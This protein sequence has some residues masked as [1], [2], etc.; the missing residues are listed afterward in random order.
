VKIFKLKGLSK[1][2][3]LRA[4]MYRRSARLQGSIGLLDYSEQALR[5]LHLWESTGVGGVDKG[6][7]GYAYGKWLVDITVKAWVEDIQAGDACKAEFLT[8]ALQRLHNTS[9]LQHVITGELF[10]WRSYSVAELQNLFMR[11]P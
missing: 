7:N 9:K 1:K 5:E 10:A 6:R 4:A 11:K 8:T 3:A 2:Y